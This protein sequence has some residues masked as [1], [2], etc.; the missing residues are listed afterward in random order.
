M[1]TMDNNERDQLKM[2]KRFIKDMSLPIPVAHEPYF[3]H[4][5]ETIDKDFHSKEKWKL[6]QDMGLKSFQELEDLSTRVMSE[7]VEKIQSTEAF[8]RWERESEAPE[9]QKPRVRRRWE[10]EAT[11]KPVIQ[12]KLY[13]SAG[14]K[15]LY[16]ESN[17]GKSF[18]SI[19]LTSANF[20][21]FRNYSKEMVLNYSSYYDLIA[22]VTEHEY[23]R[24][25]KHFRMLV[26]TQFHPTRQHT[27]WRDLIQR[28]ISILIEGH[29]LVEEEDIS[30][31]SL[32]EVVFSL[33]G[34]ISKEEL[35]ERVNDIREALSIESFG[36]SLKIEAFHLTQLEGH[37]NKGEKYFIKQHLYPHKGK[38]DF[39]CIPKFFFL[40][41]YKHYMNLPPSGK[42]LVFYHCGLLSTHLTPLYDVEIK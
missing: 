24:K 39:K 15:N 26:F 29:G 17:C 9:P 30:A 2:R 4:G 32:D 21:A 6:F 41:V 38:I 5:L 35:E 8:K 34:D 1:S 12:Q 19:D 42:D 14:G 28:I 22:S 16:K 27:M 11:E 31:L 25:S 33:P 40:Q 10:Q 20:L 7:L 36:D 23:F 37:V 3:T 13:K 18:I